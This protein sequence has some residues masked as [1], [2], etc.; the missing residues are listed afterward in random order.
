M[1]R[2]VGYV[3]HGNGTHKARNVLQDEAL[4]LSGHALLQKSESRLL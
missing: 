1:R 4:L 2:Y 3:I